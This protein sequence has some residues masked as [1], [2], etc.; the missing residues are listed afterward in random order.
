MS[1]IKQM[2]QA[3]ADRAARIEEIDNMLGTAGA[4]YKALCAEKRDLGDE[5]EVLNNMLDTSEWGKFSNH[6]T[7]ERIAA[8]RQRLGL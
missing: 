8:A 3:R 7:P 2:E 5:W 1:D 6:I 4:S